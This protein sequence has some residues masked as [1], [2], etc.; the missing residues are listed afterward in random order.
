MLLLHGEESFLVN[1]EARR[2]LDE[3]R[4][5][6]VSDFGFEALD[7]GAV[8]AERLRDAVLQAP[9]LDPYRVVAVRG[10]PVRRADPLAPA[11]KDVPESTRLLLTVN[12]K[13]PAAARLQL[14][15]LILNDIPPES[16]VDY[17]TEWSEED[18]SDFSRASWKDINQIVEGEED[19]AAG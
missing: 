12:G 5:A 14:A 19:A 4:E 16:V 1:D 2:T 10:L 7:P 9:F 13:L 18:L 15:A 11:L 3:W 17:R 8:T 6:L